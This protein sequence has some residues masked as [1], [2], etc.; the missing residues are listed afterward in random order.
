MFERC[1]FGLFGFVGDGWTD[2]AR[3]E[4]HK[5]GTFFDLA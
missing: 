1:Q 3:A 2:W 5:L 4:A